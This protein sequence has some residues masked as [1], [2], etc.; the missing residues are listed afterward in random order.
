M[1]L[2][3]GHI[4]LFI[5]LSFSLFIYSFIYLFIYHLLNVDNVQLKEV[6][7]KNRLH[8]N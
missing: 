5:Y 4:Y 6:S 7:H 8:T 1:S 3:L 2:Y